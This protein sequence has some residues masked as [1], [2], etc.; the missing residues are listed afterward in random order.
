MFLE[1]LFVGCSNVASRLKAQSGSFILAPL[2]PKGTENPMDDLLKKMSLN[3]T[4]PEKHKN[5]IL[6][7]LDRLCINEYTVYSD[8][9][10]LSR[11]LTAKPFL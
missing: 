10:S 3:I 7:D 9:E 1:P 4:I 6:K 11:S 8:L 2:L 5:D